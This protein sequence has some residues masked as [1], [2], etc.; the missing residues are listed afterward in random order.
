MRRF[1]DNCPFEVED[2]FLPK[3]VEP[4]RAPAEMAIIEGII[5]RLPGDLSDLKVARDAQ[6]PT[7]FLQF[8]FFDWLP[9]DSSTNPVES[10]R[11]LAKA[12]VS[13]PRRF[14]LLSNL[15]G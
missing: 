2:I 14:D 6:V 8:G 4:S 9:V 10:V 13:L 12:M 3:Q 7:E 1:D 15:R 5:I 11:E